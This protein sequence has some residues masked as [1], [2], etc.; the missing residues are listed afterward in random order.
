MKDQN[1]TAALDSLEQASK[2]NRILRHQLAAKC[3][4][5]FELSGRL[6][7]ADRINE[8]QA[9]KIVS[10]QKALNGQAKN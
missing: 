10:L 7:F 6:G 3:K 8:A 9:R 5:I 4:E 2:T 1:L